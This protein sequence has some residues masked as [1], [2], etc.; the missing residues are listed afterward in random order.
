[1]SSD[2]DAPV[3]ARRALRFEWTPGT[4]R[5]PVLV[6]GHAVL[7]GSK[8][9][10]GALAGRAAVLIVFGDVNEVA[11]VEATVGLAVGGQRLGHQRGHAGLVAI[12]NL[13]TFEV[14]AIGNDG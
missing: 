9:L 2:L 11:F 3:D 13:F 4:G 5:G 6:Q 14:A 1:C 12:Q 10:D 7:D 8:T